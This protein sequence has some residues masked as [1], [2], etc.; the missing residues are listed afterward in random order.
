MPSA[1]SDFENEPVLSVAPMMDWTDRHCRYFFRLMS[2]TAKLYTEMVTATAVVRGDT[3]RLLEFDPF[4]RP[5]ALQLGGSDPVEMA[6]AA[7][8]ASR[9]GYDEININV[10]CPSDR[11]QS[12]SFGACL[13]AEPERVRDCYIAM[14]EAVEQPVTIKSRI[15]ID[16]HDDYAFLCNFLEIVAKGGC[17]VFVIHARKAILQGLSPKQNRDIPPLCYDR[18]YRVKKDFPQLRIV[19]NGG[20]RS[21]DDAQEHLLHV[22][23]VMIG[24][25]AYRNPWILSEFDD[26]L[27]PGRPLE[28]RAEVIK[29]YIPYISDQLDRGVRLHSMTRHM[30]GLFAG[31][32]GARAWRRELSRQGSNASADI[33]VIQHALERVA[34]MTQ[35]AQARL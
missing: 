5:L 6:E 16:H 14:Q 11:V 25:E 22:D 33:S 23:G 15:G 17:Q 19:I 35:I 18:V 24:R 28:S 32:P 9:F 3:R 29:A 20:I 4:E 1:M 27:G 30:L 26:R 2:P 12:G 7:R 31:Q 21:T 8:I 13:M 10:G 34:E